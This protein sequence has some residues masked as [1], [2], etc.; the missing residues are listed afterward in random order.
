MHRL[1]VDAEAYQDVD[2]IMAWHESQKQ[3]LGL[4]FLL[5]F[6]EAVSFLKQNPFAC[7]VEFGVIR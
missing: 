7:Q 5:K 2:E 6:D 3:G 4:D 1:I